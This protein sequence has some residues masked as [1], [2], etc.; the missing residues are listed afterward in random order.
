MR[1]RWLPSR[2]CTCLKCTNQASCA[3]TKQAVHQ[4]SKP[5]PS[6]LLVQLRQLHPL[7]VSG[8]KPMP[9]AWLVQ[10]R[11]L[12]PL[13]VSD[14]KPMP[15]ALL[16]QLRQLHPLEISGT[17]TLLRTKKRAE[18]PVSPHT[19]WCNT[20]LSTH[21]KRS[22]RIKRLSLF[23]SKPYHFFLSCHYRF[24]FIIASISTNSLPI[25]RL[26]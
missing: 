12:H 10:L 15:S 5:M 9:F 2:G 16:V 3:P 18:S 22:S 24:C 19:Q 20:E 1:I 13:E 26:R 8:S 17:P 14:S 25:F 4:P 23:Q 7:E 21:I 6:A 11:Q